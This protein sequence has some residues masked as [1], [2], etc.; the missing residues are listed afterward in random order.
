MD[1]GI[2]PKAPCRSGQEEASGLVVPFG[3]EFRK[4]LFVNREVHPI[5]KALAVAVAAGL[6][7]EGF[8]DRFPKGFIEAVVVEFPGVMR[9]FPGLPEGVLPFVG[10]TGTPPNPIKVTDGSGHW[11]MDLRPVFCFPIWGFEDDLLAS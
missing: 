9:V 6:L 4:V 3:R 2:W 1:S 5:L 8:E 7:E 10:A 11:S